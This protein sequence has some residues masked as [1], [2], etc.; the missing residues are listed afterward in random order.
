[1]HFKVVFSSV[2]ERLRKKSLRWNSSKI[3]EGVNWKLNRLSFKWLF[4]ERVLHVNDR[5]ELVDACMHVA[6]YSV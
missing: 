5:L 4:K 6:Q 2:E 3:H 1:M